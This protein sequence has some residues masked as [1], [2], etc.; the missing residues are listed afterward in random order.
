MMGRTGMLA[1]LQSVCKDG[2]S[3]GAVGQYSLGVW[4]EN[5]APILALTYKGPVAS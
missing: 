3:R 1:G 2:S 5:G 4:V